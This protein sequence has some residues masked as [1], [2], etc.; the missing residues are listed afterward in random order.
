MVEVG[1]GRVCVGLVQAEATHRRRAA[2]EHHACLQRSGALRREATTSRG[3]STSSQLAPSFDAGPSDT[4]RRGVTESDDTACWR[5]RSQ[6]ARRDERNRVRTTASDYRNRVGA[7]TALVHPGSIPAPSQ[8]RRKGRYCLQER[9]KRVDK[10]D[11]LAPICRAVACGALRRRSSCPASDGEAIAS[12]RRRM[13]AVARAQRRR[14]E[15]AVSAPARGQSYRPTR[16]P[17]PVSRER[18]DQR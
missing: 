8:G 9:G 12:R 4:P 14:C 2:Q 17:S 18:P 16:V 5:R 15:S 6:Q 1:G 3:N 11:S 7:I 10:S 13:A